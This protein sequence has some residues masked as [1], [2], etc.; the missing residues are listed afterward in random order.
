MDVLQ[1]KATTRVQHLGHDQL[2]TFGCGTELD[3]RQWSSVFR[4]LAAAGLLA[5]DLDGYGSLKLNA[6]SW[7]VL[8]G[9][10]PVSLRRDPAPAAETSRPGRAASGAEDSELL[11]A[12]E[13]RELWEKLRALRRR[14]AEEQGVPP[15]A[16]FPDRSLLDMLRHRPRDKAE[17]SLVHGV[18]KAKLAAYGAA[19]LEILLNHEYEN[20]RP[21]TVQDFPPALVEKQ[22]RPAPK[23]R[24]LKPSARASLEL[25]QDLGDAAAVA[26]A[27]GVKPATVMAHLTEAVAAGE[28]D[29][30]QAS[31]LDPD[32]LREVRDILKAF[33]TRGITAL[34]PVFDTLHGLYAYETLRMVRASL[35]K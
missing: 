12:E 32:S 33:Q 5:T 7:E 27:R 16:V 6:V 28:I 17:L 2:K 18:G 3:R 30:E 24:G 11:Q 29:V 21:D 34:T 13:A 9:E 1:G 14:L 26:E 25:F 19:F 35:E 22:R 20:G 4:Q 10:R 8:R 31:G 15:Y 23:P